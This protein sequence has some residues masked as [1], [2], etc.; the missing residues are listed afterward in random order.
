MKGR[1]L[2]VGLFALAVALSWPGP[3]PGE[4]G[5]WGVPSGLEGRGNIAGMSL[6][7][8]LFG[9]TEP[10]PQRGA[11]TEER[12]RLR[13]RAGLRDALSSE[14]AASDSAYWQA[15]LDRPVKSARH[16]PARTAPAVST[17]PDGWLPTVR[18]PSGKAAE[19]PRAGDGPGPAGRMRAESE[20]RLS[21]KPEMKGTAPGAPAPAVRGARRDA[22]FDGRRAG[23]ASGR[24][25]RNTAAVP[26]SSWSPA[27]R[28]KEPAEKAAKPP[29]PPTLSDW[30]GRGTLKAPGRRLKPPTFTPLKD[31]F[32]A[33]LPD[34]RPYERATPP[35]EAV[36]SLVPPD[37]RP[38]Y[39]DWLDAD[40]RKKRGSK[41][42]W[43]QDGADWLFHAGKA[44]GAPREGRWSWLL[45]YD[46]RFWTV[47]DG[48]QRL[49]RHGE[50]WWWRTE[51][52]WFLLKG[53]Q[54]WAYRHFPEWEG[55]G[56]I[57][58]TK[59]TQVVYSADGARLAVLTPGRDTVV[60]DAAT[61]EVLA[62]FPAA[63]KPA[64][65][66]AP[67]LED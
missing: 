5:S 32:P 16:D 57:H 21:H 49:A 13:P 53:G 60:F 48:A 65:A 1:L 42:H 14:S 2:G 58:P 26:A 30:L 24:L 38:L 27:E 33:R 56:F 39:E 35:P 43:H 31:L 29:K 41:P 34:G 59:G 52:G 64:A 25:T 37:E 61:G 18:R 23:G 46:R 47:A 7:K 67:F 28:K 8:G 22:D 15:V 50:A 45:E 12:A 20:R 51:D 55:H 19:R 36:E 63:E 6:V 40:E 10:T 62:R 4:G 54:A 17:P 3:E 66:L 11:L 44:W 9:R